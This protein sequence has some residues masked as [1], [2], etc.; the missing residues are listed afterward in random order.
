MSHPYLLS[1]VGAEALLIGMIVARLRTALHLSK[2]KRK[3]RSGPILLPE[4][5]SDDTKGRDAGSP[6]P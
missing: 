3:R 5:R 4:F 6:H 1:G 2:R